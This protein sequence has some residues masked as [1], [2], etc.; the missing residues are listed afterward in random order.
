MMTASVRLQMIPNFLWLLHL[1]I[2]LSVSDPI[3]IKCELNSLQMWNRDIV[4]LQ[5][6]RQRERA[7]ESMSLTILKDLTFYTNHAP[8]VNDDCRCLNRIHRAAVMLFGSAVALYLTTL[9]LFSS[10]LLSP[11]SVFLHLL[12]V[13]SPADP[14]T[15]VVTIFWEVDI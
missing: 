3:C 5:R 1:C 14:Y 7:R 6:E 12:L 10:R 2:L 13:S 15:F 4:W 8:K 11:F 9:P